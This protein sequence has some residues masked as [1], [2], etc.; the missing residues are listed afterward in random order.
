MLLRVEDLDGPRIKADAAQ[1][2]IDL[3]AWLGM[4]WDEGP[5]YQSADLS[6]YKDALRRL[7]AAG[8]IYPCRAT[9]SQLVAAAVSAPN[10]GDH[11]V[12]YSGLSRPDDVTPFD[13]DDPAHVGAAWRLRAADE[14]ITLRDELR[15]EVSHNVQQSVG[16]FVVATKAGLPAY[17]LAVVVDD[18]RQGVTH[19]VR[20]D[21]L[22]HS[23]HR[24]ELVRRALGID[25][26]M[27]VHTHLPM[28]IGEDGR[29][30]AK[31][32][33]DTRLDAYRKRGVHAERVIGL[34]AEW[35]GIG[36]R[37]EM[38]AREFTERFRIDAMPTDAVVFTAADDAWL[39]DGVPGR[40][41]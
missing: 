2:A 26:S 41:G 19:I 23:T 25:S 3:L 11:E 31:R 29:R 5:V 21:D 17:Q 24:Q 38:G 1:L 18:H 28:V 13:F 39:M 37:Q 7:A 9:R 10:K 15:G 40:S 34:L 22:L 32:H 4:D 6:P 36:P 12:R 30:L 27:I 20:G 14:A 16:D 33:G 8:A 35:C